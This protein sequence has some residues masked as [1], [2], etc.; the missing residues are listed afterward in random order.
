MSLLEPNKQ[1]LRVTETD[2][3]DSIVSRNMQCV[4]EK[5]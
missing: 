5:G 1:A 4:P 2:T 3:Y